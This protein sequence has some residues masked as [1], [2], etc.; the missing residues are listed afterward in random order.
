ML[1]LYLSNDVGLT[2]K[3]MMNTGLDDIVN[4]EEVCG[5]ELLAFCEAVSCHKQIIK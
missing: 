2:I 5:D 1:L 4:T 3:L